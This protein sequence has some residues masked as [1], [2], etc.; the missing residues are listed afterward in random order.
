[1]F[2]HFSRLEIGVDRFNSAFAGPYHENFLWTW[3]LKEAVEK[4]RPSFGR[5]AGRDVANSM[6]PTKHRAYFRLLVLRC[7]S[8]HVSRPPR[9]RAGRN[10]LPRHRRQGQGAN[11][12]DEV[13]QQAEEERARDVPAVPPAHPPPQDVPAPP[14]RAFEAV[15][16]VVPAAPMEYVRNM[17]DN[18]IH[19]MLGPGAL[20]CGSKMPQRHQLLQSYAHLGVRKLCLKN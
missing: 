9:Y 4:E 15:E 7:N 17:R 12:V 19:R 1:M 2:K 10:F 3:P 14:L 16:P 5:D 20:R 11:K 6:T 18:R 13:P 8:S